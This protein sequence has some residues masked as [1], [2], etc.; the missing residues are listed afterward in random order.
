MKGM[1][2]PKLWRL[3]QGRAVRTLLNSSFL[4]RCLS[5]GLENYR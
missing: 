3:D 5:P 1:L 4:L 2:T